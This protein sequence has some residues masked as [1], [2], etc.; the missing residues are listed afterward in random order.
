MAKRF[1]NCE[2]DPILIVCQFERIMGEH[3]AVVSRCGPSMKSSEVQKAV[4]GLNRNW[5][6]SRLF[7]AALLLAGAG[8]ATVATANSSRRRER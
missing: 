6:W 8:E 2:A 7:V 3:E 4:S 5:G 1:C